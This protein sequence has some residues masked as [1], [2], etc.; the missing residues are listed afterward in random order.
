V[1]KYVKETTPDKVM[2]GVIEV[3]CDEALSAP[4]RACDV[5]SKEGLAKVVTNALRRSL[6]KI[7]EFAGDWAKPLFE[8]AVAS[9]IEC[10]YDTQSV[11]KKEGESDGSK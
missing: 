2:L 1:R 10:A 4:P 7:P 11:V 8:A 6:A 9:A 3:W 5:M